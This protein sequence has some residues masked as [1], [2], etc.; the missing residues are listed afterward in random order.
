[1]AFNGSGTFNRIYDWTTDEGNGINIEAS[2]MDGEDDGFA[3]GL[4]TCITKDGQTTVTANIPM[5]SKKITGLTVGSARTDSIS[6][7]QVQD[8]TYTTLGTSGGSADA[9]T[10]TPSPAIA[11]YTAGQEYVIKFHAVNTTAST[12]NTSALGTRDLKKWDGAGA[13]V[14]LEAGDIQIQHYRIFDDGTDIMVLNPEKPA[15]ISFPSGG[16]LTI[17]TGAITVTQSQHTV[18]TESD[19]ATDDLDTINGGNTGQ[20]LILSTANS[21]RDVVLK[22]AT[23]NIICPESIDI[24]LGVTNDKAVLQYDGTNWIVLS[25]SVANDANAGS[26][27]LLATV[28]ASSSATVD[29]DNF[30]DST[31]D[32]YMVTYSNVLAATDAVDFYT[33]F[34]TGATPT[35]QAS[36]YRYSKTGGRAGSVVQRDS[37]NS[38]AAAIIMND[39]GVNSLGNVAGEEVSGVMYIHG[40]ASAVH[41]SCHYSQSREDADDFMQQEVG[42]G[43]WDSTTAVTSVRFLMSSGNVASGEF[44]LYGIKKS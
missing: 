7:G 16:E 5:N 43:K 3:T 11:A 2:R 34:G 33:R 12:L 8:G 9:Y 14:A 20:I 26:V 41:T 30:L 29:F 6:L 27:K 17:A 40:P 15:R 25:Y 32:T 10:A 39:S 37:S 36:L 35:Y 42:S 23:G 44:K 21:A 13:K 1:M 4:S 38:T 22:N 18:D 31:Y 19:A 24:T 28:T